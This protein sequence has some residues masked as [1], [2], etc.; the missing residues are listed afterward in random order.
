ML[1]SYTMK[2]KSEEQVMKKCSKCDVVKPLDE[3][4][5]HS[6]YGDGHRGQ[7]KECRKE[8]YS[9]RYKNRREELSEAAK[10]YHQDN[11]EKHNLYSKQYNQ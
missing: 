10:K 1:W 7:C 8:Y 5:K 3:F 4:S 9:Q 6:K 11:K 2:T